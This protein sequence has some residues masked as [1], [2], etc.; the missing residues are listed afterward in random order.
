MG[1]LSDDYCLVRDDPAVAYR[2]HTT[3][4]VFDD[5]VSRFASLPEPVAGASLARGDEDE[6]PKAL[7]LLHETMPDRLLSSAPV[8]VVLVADARGGDHARLEPLS[9][10]ETLRTVAPHALWQMSIEPD[11]E[12]AALATLFASVPC[13]RLVLSTDRAANPPLVQEA[14]DRA[15]YA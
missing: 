1:F 9:G 3:A 11:R 5:D 13:Y 7:Y 4:R 12:L 2:L 8:R 6:E 15:A 14:L 10:G